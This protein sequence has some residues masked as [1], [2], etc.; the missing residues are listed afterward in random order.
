MQ[1]TDKQFARSAA[2]RL[3]HKYRLPAHELDDLLHLANIGVWAA[4]LTWDESLAA[5]ETWRYRCVQ[6]ELIDYLRKRGYFKSRSRAQHIH[7][8]LTGEPQADFEIEQRALDHVDGSTLFTHLKRLR[9]RRQAYIIRRV[10]E[11]ANF[12]EIGTE[13]GISR[14]WTCRGYHKGIQRLRSIVGVTPGT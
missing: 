4:K 6:R 11:G 5:W 1:K 14:S 7:A 10:M 12:E 3:H 13:L 2:A 8:S 9:N